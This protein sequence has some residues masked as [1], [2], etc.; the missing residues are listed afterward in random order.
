LAAHAREFTIAG[1]YEFFARPEWNALVKAYGLQ[2]RSERQMQPEFMIKAA[3]GGEVD[4]IS[5]Y[6]SDGQIA[7]NDLVVLDDPRHAIPPYDAILLLSPKRAHDGKLI[8]ALWPLLGAIPVATMRAANARA[9]NGNTSAD[10][11]A[12]WLAVEIAKVR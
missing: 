11:T 5:A 4:V 2:F 3:A 8:E 9:G 10:E 7:A 6:T 12:K 1:D